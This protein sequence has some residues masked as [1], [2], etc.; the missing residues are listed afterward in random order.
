[1]KTV[2]DFSFDYA[3]VCS[4]DRLFMAKRHTLGDSQMSTSS[5]YR[6]EN[7]PPLVLHVTGARPNFPKAAPVIAA[8]EDRGVPQLLVHTG[9]HYDPK[10]SDVFF[11]QLGLPA[12]DVNL[13]VGSGRHG[14]QTAAIMTG[15]ED[16][17]ERHRPDMVVVYGDVNSTVAASLVAAKMGV[18]TAHVE[19]GLRSFDLSM[20]EEINRMVT[21]RLADL[22]LVT[23]PDAIAHLAREGVPSEHIHLVGNPMIDTLL[24]LRPRFA[25]EAVRAEL[26]LPDPY[27]VATL[28]RPGNVDRSDDIRELV[29]AMHAVAD[30]ARVVLPLHPRG[31]E[32]LRDAGLFDH[33]GMQIV[34]PYGYLEFMGLVEGAAAVVTDSGGVQEETTVLGVP[35]LTLRPNTERP[36]TITHGTNRLVRRDNLA[37]HV[38]QVLKQGRLSHWPV[39]PLWDGSA[40]VRCADIIAQRLAG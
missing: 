14:A 27:V 10:M 23:S 15:L 26:D 39:P 3:K 18:P 31:R 21:D 8:L 19:A 17:F 1:M 7:M 5:T 35:C 32:R 2:M 40:G 33:P 9:Q 28:H 30:L 13:G 24:R 11:T 12:P 36:V 34:E 22:L 16:L 25:G 29:G 37:E 4:A 20:P 6:E 38:A